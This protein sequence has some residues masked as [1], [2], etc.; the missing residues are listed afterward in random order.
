MFGGLFVFLGH[1]LLGDFIFGKFCLSSSLCFLF[2]D[3]IQA[4]PLIELIP[5]ISVKYSTGM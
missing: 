5:E 3:S 4:V 1:F 2:W